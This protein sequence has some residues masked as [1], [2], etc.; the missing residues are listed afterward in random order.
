MYAETTPEQRRAGMAAFRAK[1]LKAH[2]AMLAGGD[3]NTLK[4]G[5]VGEAARKYHADMIDSIKAAQVRL[6]E[7]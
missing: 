4:G 7:V 3:P 5:K 6:G 2:T 1:M